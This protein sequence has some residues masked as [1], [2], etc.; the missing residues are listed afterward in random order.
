MSTLTL[1]RIDLIMN[2]HHKKKKNYR[3]QLCDHVSL[4]F[5]DAYKK[6]LCDTRA[7]SW[8]AGGQV[9]EIQSAI[10]GKQLLVD[11]GTFSRHLSFCEVFQKA[12]TMWT[13]P[14]VSLLLFVSLFHGCRNFVCPRICR[15]FSNAIRCNNITQGAA[16]V[17]DHR[18]RR[19]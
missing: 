16:P 19:L 3:A 7:T 2:R 6:S 4:S 8:E 18:D 12:P 13:S 15:C 14:S 10:K 11:E 17:M 5:S 9:I 1:L